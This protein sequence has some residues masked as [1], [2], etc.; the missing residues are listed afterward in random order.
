M[1]I[2]SGRDDAVDPA[3]LEGL[4]RLQDQ[5]YDVFLEQSRI[6]IGGALAPRVLKGKKSNDATASDRTGRCY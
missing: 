5:E 4:R 1:D 6:D 2:G 3:I